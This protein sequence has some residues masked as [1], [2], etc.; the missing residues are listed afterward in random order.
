MTVT[1]WVGLQVRAAFADRP[2]WVDRAKAAAAPSA[3]C[4]TLSSRG[5]G[6]YACTSPEIKLTYHLLSKSASGFLRSQLHARYNT[7]NEFSCRFLGEMQQ[8]F[9]ISPKQGWTWFTLVRDPVQRFLSAAHHVAANEYPHPAVTY[10]N[11]NWQRRAGRRTSRA[12]PLN[13]SERL[14]MIEYLVTQGNWSDVHFQSQWASV[15]KAAMLAP[16]LVAQ[17]FIGETCAAS[18]LLGSMRGYESARERAR[19]DASISV[20][21]AFNMSRHSNRRRHVEC[22]ATGK[23]P[24]AVDRA[25][26]EPHDRHCLGGLTEKGLQADRFETAESVEMREVALTEEQIARIQVH[27][28]LDYECLRLPRL[29]PGVEECARP[30]ALL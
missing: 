27:Y 24:A 22:H 26:G 6:P 1:N 29:P 9:D 4:S 15:R 14:A 21:K 8:R 18:E 16:D 7:T 3:S 5:E 30:T 20:E 17:G 23:S 13:Q 2:R 12:Y 11:G 25:D 28:Q 19:R 10:R